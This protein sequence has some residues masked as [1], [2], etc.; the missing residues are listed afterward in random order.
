MIEWWVAVA[1]GEGAEAFL[2]TQV[3][4]GIHSPIWHLRLLAQH[5][6]CC[7]SQEY[8][9]GKLNRSALSMAEHNKQNNESNL[10]L[11]MGIGVALGT[12]IGVAMDQLAMG[13][14]LGVAFGAAY[15]FATKKKP[16]S[17]DDKSD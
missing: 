9:I 14:A 10:G 13:V 15:G 3:T 12:A 16:D 1:T 11:S 7:Y 6:L 2:G 17:D 4:L 5:Q 8:I